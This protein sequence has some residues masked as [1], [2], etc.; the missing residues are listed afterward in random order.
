MKRVTA[1]LLLLAGLCCFAT[2]RT[3]LLKD[4]AY[5]K[6]IRKDH[7]RLFFNKEMIPAIR[8]TAK[9]RPAEFNDLKRIVDRLPDDAPY[10]E[11]TDKFERRPDGTIKPKK[12]GGIQGYSLLK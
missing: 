7:P 10:I 12:A 9:A 8:A 6:K 4:G 1:F 5:L 2:D 11:L 3:G